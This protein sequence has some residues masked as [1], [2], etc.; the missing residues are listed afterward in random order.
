MHALRVWG[1]SLRPEARGILG[2]VAATLCFA[3]MDSIVKAL[4]GQLPPMQVVWA[5]YTVHSLLVVVI[6][7]PRLG[8][9]L[10][11]R[12]LK[13]QLA[14]SVLLFGMTLL[15]FT[16][17]KFLPFAEAVSLL[18][19][20]PLMITVLAALMLH[21]RVGARR[22]IGVGIG[23]LGALVLLRPGLGVM[24]T[25][26]LLGLGAAA[27]QAAYQ[28]A[29]RML[30]PGDSIWTTLIYSTG[31]GALAA[32]C[33]MPFV[34][35]TPDAGAAGLM[36]LT[37]IFGFGAHLCL[38]WAYSQAE[39][40]AVAPFNYCAPVWATMAGLF[41]F[42]EVPAPTT[43]IGAVIIVGAGLYVWRRERLAEPIPPAS[44]FPRAGPSRSSHRG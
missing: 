41:V 8:S 29:T 32:S 18:Q 25:A 7:L 17:L 22:W 6:F 35:V 9:I 5:R 14:R 13:L 19:I 2:M 43:L 21:E 20:A 15:Y 27:F 3:I 1:A 16:T 24:Q 40:S 4:S 44:P 33:A 37:G 30:G 10:R 12:H 39:A 42:G 11:T 23:F 26:A 36:V 38:V 31:F 34:W 28:V